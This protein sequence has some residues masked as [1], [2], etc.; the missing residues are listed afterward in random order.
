MRYQLTLASKAI[1][2]RTIQ[3]SLGMGY[4]T[5]LAK[6]LAARDRAYE[7]PGRLFDLRHG[8]ETSNIVQ[9]KDLD[10][11]EES[12]RNAVRYQPTKIA[13]F[14]EVVRRLPIEDRNR[15]AFV[16]F[17]CGKGRCLLLAADAG[18]GSVMGIELSPPLCEA[19][20]RNAGIFRSGH[21][22][23]RINVQ[24]SD[25]AAAALPDSPSVYFFYNPFNAT[26]MNAAVDNIARHL[27]ASA[28][29][30]FIAYV[31]PIHKTAIETAGFQLIDSGRRRGEDW[32][33]WHR[34]AA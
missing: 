10:M 17:G 27:R 7:L 24:S 21:H 8:I 3:S 34:P 31:N 5:L 9:A 18:F 16:D 19:A 22:A 15:F 26:V 14:R 6:L 28:H 11:P 13:V 12:R 29:E 30:A 20:T 32:A 2:P 4:Y 33:I 25:A 23:S 1:L